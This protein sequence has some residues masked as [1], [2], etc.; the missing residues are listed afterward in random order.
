M[1]C[2]NTKRSWTC[3]MQ[4]HACIKFSSK[5]ENRWKRRL[6][7]SVRKILSIQKDRSSE[8]LQFESTE[9]LLV[10]TSANLTSQRNDH[11]DLFC[12]LHGEKKSW[13][14]SL[15]NGL[16]KKLVMNWRNNGW[17]W[18]ISKTQNNTADKKT[19]YS[20][21]AKVRRIQHTAITLCS[22]TKTSTVLKLLQ[23]HTEERKSK[24]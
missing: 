2:R 22:R 10:R 5:S 7:F 17:N 9:A 23:T 4:V 24:C 13:T 11:C 6:S 16:Q 20:Y 14:A 21:K 3:L 1:H 12:E 19:I 8:N 15:Q 18:I